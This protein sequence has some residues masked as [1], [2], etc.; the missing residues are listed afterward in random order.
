VIKEINIIK[1]CMCKQK[2]CETGVPTYN[3]NHPKLNCT[4]LTYD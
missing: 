2:L 3:R 1:N 4:Y